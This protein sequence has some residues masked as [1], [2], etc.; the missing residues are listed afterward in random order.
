MATERNIE[1]EFDTVREDL[2]KLR[3]DIAAIKNTLQEVATEKVR[4][5]VN[6]AQQ[7]FDKW[8]ETARYR[9]RASLENFASE[10]EDRPLTSIMVAFGAGVILGRIFDR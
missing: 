6:E 1:I 4:A 10:V 7:K 2:T 5:R 3:S 8:S 9:S